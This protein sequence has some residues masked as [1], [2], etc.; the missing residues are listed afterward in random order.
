[1]FPGRAVVATASLPDRRRR[2]SSSSPA[3]ASNASSRTG[4][5]HIDTADDDPSSADA[6]TLRDTPYDVDDASYAGDDTEPGLDAA[7]PMAAALRCRGGPRTHSPAPSP[8][9]STKEGGDGG[10]SK[11]T[12]EGGTLSSS[13]SPPFWLPG[14]ITFL[15]CVHKQCEQRLKIAT[16][17][18]AG[19]GQFAAAAF[20]WCSTCPLLLL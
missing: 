11:N 13:L 17:E 10:R 1:M 2:S 9:S 8:Y 7:H 19:H 12:G 6:D 18:M 14:A 20:N 15:P 16:K 5:L 3:P 4:R